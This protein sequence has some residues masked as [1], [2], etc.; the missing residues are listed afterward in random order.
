[1][2]FPSQALAQ[3]HGPARLAAACEDIAHGLLTAAVTAEDGD[4]V[5]SEDL[6]AAAVWFV[7][8]SKACR[9]ARQ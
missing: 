1:M 3:G 4:I 5:N 7:A 9:A 6:E 8:V 2:E